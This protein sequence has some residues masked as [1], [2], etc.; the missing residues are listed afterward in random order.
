[1]NKK[2]LPGAHREGQ[3]GFYAGEGRSAKCERQESVDFCPRQSPGDQ[4]QASAGLGSNQDSDGQ[5]LAQGRQ[6][7]RWWP[8]IALAYGFVCALIGLDECQDARLAADGERPGGECRLAGV[9][10]S[11]GSTLPARAGSLEYCAGARGAGSGR[12]A[13]GQRVDCQPGCAAGLWTARD[14]VFRHDGPGAGD[15]LSTRGRDS[16]GGGATSLSRLGE[17]ER[18]AIARHRGGERKGKRDVEDRQTVPSLRQEQGEERRAVVSTRRADQTVDGAQ[19]GSDQTSGSQ[20]QESDAIGGVETGADGG[21]E[22]SLVA[23][24]SAMASDR[25][26][27]NGQDFARRDY[28]GASNRQEQSGQ[29]SG[30][31]AEMADQSNRRGV[32]IWARNR[33]ESQRARNADRSDEGLQASLGSKSKAE[34]ECLRSRWER[35]QDDRGIEEAGGRES[36]DRSARESQM[37]RC[38]GRPNRSALTTREDGRCDRHAQ[39]SEIQFQSQTREKQQDVNCRWATGDGLSE[40]EQADERHSRES[41]E[42]KSSNNLKPEKVGREEKSEK[43]EGKKR[44]KGKERAVGEQKSK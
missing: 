18:E 40:F 16:Q 36:W 19:P 23:A 25:C 33:S 42:R 13:G 10:R 26:S 35:T 17:I 31:R 7:R 22:R 44:R 24:D 43:D 3:T 14:I 30:I 27:G 6:K 37:V 29:A 8:W 11:G 2:N 4:A 28:W 20:Q 32:C 1:M 39:E 34:D 5:T 9:C 21:G 38:R 12:L 15:R 41:E